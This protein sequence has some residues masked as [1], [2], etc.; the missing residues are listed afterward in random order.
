MKCSQFVTL[1]TD[2]LDGALSPRKAARVEA[3]LGECAGCAAALAQF[4]A[5]IAAS[6]M[7]SE[8]DVERIDDATLMAL[9]DAFTAEF[10]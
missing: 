7:L 10:A 9:V 3:H 4:R 6:G 2:Y 8:A 5:V 1:V